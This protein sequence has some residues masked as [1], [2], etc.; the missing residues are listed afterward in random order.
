[1]D[2][3]NQNQNPNTDPNGANGGN[4]NDVNQSGNNQTIDY[5]KI[6]QMLDG[7]LKAKE[8]T[9]LKA[10]FKQQGVSQEDMEKYIADFKAQQ[11]DTTPDVDGLNAQIEAKDKEI[12]ELNAKLATMALT[13]TVNGL[14]DELGFEVKNTKYIM[15]SAELEGAIKENGEVDTAKV[16]AAVKQFLDDVPNFKKSATINNRTFKHDNVGAGKPEGNN[17]NNSGNKPKTV[18]GKIDAIFT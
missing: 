16:K 17:G 18:R 14:A 10:Y 3:L 7:T 5:A 8:E 11:K 9:A 12:A 15:K 1:M 2:N 6:Q 4:G 13:D